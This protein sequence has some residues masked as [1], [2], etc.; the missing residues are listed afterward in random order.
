[1]ALN[2][3]LDILKRIREKNPTLSVRIDESQIICEWDAAVGAIIAKH[4]RAL[5][6]KD[7]VLFVQVDHPVW[8]TELHLRKHQILAKLSEK[9]PKVKIKDLFFVDPI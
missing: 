8:K 4:A 2:S 3:F 9:N 7:G 1:M 5:K 6:I